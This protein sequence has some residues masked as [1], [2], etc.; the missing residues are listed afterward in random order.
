[1]KSS[2]SD[3]CA[4]STKLNL[5]YKLGDKEGTSTILPA[6]VLGVKISCPSYFI[7]VYLLLRMDSIFVLSRCF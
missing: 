1:M 2:A 4:L 3:L 7:G 5:V 6:G